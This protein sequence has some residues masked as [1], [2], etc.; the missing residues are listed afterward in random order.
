YGSN[1]NRAGMARRCPDSAPVGPVVLEDWQLTF[2]GVADI[3]R[4]PGARTYGALWEIS[5][6]DLGR[7]DRYEGFP[8]LYGRQLLPVHL[9][10]E[11]VSA[12]T[13]V[14]TERDAY[15]GLPSPS[16][17]ATIREGYEEWGLPKLDLELAVARVRERLF[18]LG[19]RRFEPD[20]PKRL[21]PV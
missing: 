5:Q 13:Y 17:V 1:L 20:G 2:Q 16:Y 15:L 10:D 9:G 18:D 8:S 12:V 4:K 7:L 11:E 3:E 19:V 21:R 6:R 14:M